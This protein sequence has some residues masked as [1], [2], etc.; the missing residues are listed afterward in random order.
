MTSSDILADE[1]V[2]LRVDPRQGRVVRRV[3]LRLGA[4]GLSTGSGSDVV[5]LAAISV[6]GP[7]TINTGAGADRLHL[8]DGAVFEAIVTAD[9]G[10]GADPFQ[11]GLVEESHLA[12]A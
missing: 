1:Y 4:E 12:A 5:S 2:L 3:P 7:T 8:L 6:A 10:G 9:L 11:A